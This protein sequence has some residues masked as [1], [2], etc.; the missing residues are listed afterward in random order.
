MPVI[1]VTMAPA[2]KEVKKELIE[3]L[4]ATAVEVTGIPIQS[5]TVALHE[6]PTNSLGVAGQTVEEM[7]KGHS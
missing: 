7:L 4:T 6:L 3:K 1:A 2:T 5:F